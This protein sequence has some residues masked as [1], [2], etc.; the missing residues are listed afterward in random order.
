MYS[1][2]RGHITHLRLDHIGRLVYIS[3]E[4]LPDDGG[5]ITQDGILLR[6]VYEP[7]RDPFLHPSDNDWSNTDADSDTAPINLEQRPIQTRIHGTPRLHKRSAWKPICN[8]YLYSLPMKWINSHC[9]LM[10]SSIIQCTAASSIGRAQ[11]VSM[12]YSRDLPILTISNVNLS[13]TVVKA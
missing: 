12:S 8:Q 6:L 13:P 4:P 11:L 10:R 9:F 5:A 1:Y 3:A 7:H 2:I